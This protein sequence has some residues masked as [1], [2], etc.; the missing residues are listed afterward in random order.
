MG[1]LVT[2][3]RM[4]PKLLRNVFFLMQVFI[5]NAV[6][7]NLEIHKVKNST[8]ITNFEI[9]D[10]DHK[11][12]EQY[13]IE[14]KN[15]LHNSM[16]ENLDRPLSA[17]TNKHCFVVIDNV[18]QLDVP[19]IGENPVILRSIVPVVAVV[20]KAPAKLFYGPRFLTN[21]NFTSE[22]YNVSCPLS[23]FLL[24]ES[25]NVFCLRLNIGR[26]WRRIK[27]WNCN[28]QI[29]LFPLSYYYKIYGTLLN[30]YSVQNLRP[31]TLFPDLSPGVQIFVME[32]KHC[33]INHNSTKLFEK[34]L[35]QLYEGHYWETKKYCKDILMCF[36][37]KRKLSH[38]ND[39]Y[40]LSPKYTVVISAMI[41]LKLCVES[42]DMID[43][44]SLETTTGLI[45]RRYSSGPCLHL[46]LI[47]YGCSLIKVG[48][49]W[50]V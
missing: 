7:G 12:M 11:K 2:L 4:M 45:F 6:L 19:A 37:T 40:S 31:L 39:K 1:K 42:K 50:F 3:I 20:A 46:S 36:G 22:E 13:F 16:I 5:H 21:K 25:L 14:M 34:D 10:W 32:R 29:G 8:R 41:L 48:T 26:Y 17:L 44:C 43:F 30:H 27:P 18:R 49:L 28:V 38:A 15:D 47:H 24:P 23:R 33:N 9:E 35:K